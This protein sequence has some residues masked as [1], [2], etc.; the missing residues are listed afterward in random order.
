MNTIGAII[1][2]FDGVL[3]ESNQAKSRAFEDF[4]ALYPA[5]HDAM[6]AYHLEHYAT[7][8]MAKFEYYVNELMGRPG[9]EG[10]VNTMLN[11]FS[12]LVK[13][14]VIASPDV[15]GAREFLK[16]FSQRVP[17]Y[18]SSVTP[19]DELREIVKARGIACFLTEVFGNPPLKKVDAIRKIIAEEGLAPSRVAFIGD[20]HSDYQAAQRTGVGFFG[21]DS[22]FG[23][24]E[25]PI[26]LFDDLFDIAEALRTR[27]KG[28]D[29]GF[30]R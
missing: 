10:L 1:L 27:I 6:L 23:F 16:E 3:A 11:Q 7:S 19:Q 15:P 26:P 24:E 29:N 13:G 9:D 4:F 22:G 30:E 8:R 12:G 20:S 25:A 5:Y 21:R 18:I 28:K 14:R 2:D 17:L